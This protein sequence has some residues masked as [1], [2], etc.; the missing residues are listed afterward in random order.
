MI[1]LGQEESLLMPFVDNFLW[2]G[3]IAANQAE[4]AYLEDGKGLSTADMIIGGN[5][6]TPRMFYPQINPDVFYPSHGAIDF[7]HR[8]KE[9]VALF[10]EMGWSVFRT[11][12]NWSRIYPNGYD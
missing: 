10:A 3:A 4:G 11:S 8:Y 1:L 7:Y 5:V 2:G 12:I 9:D 6:N